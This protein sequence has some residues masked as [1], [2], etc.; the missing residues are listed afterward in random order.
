MDVC[1]GGE[2]SRIEKVPIRS[3]GCLKRPREATGEKGNSHSSCEGM[4]RWHASWGE[5]HG[6]RFSSLADLTSPNGGLR[7]RIS[8]FSI[9]ID[10][11]C[12]YSGPPYTKKKELFCSAK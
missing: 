1:I 8:S 9:P 3:L 5:I 11:S 7:Q 12:R 2:P 10:D 6:E 4:A